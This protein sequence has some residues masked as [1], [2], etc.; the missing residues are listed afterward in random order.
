VHRLAFEH[1]GP[2][3][4]TC[5]SIDASDEMLFDW[6]CT[7]QFN[8]KSLSEQRSACVVRWNPLYWICFIVTFLSLWLGREGHRLVGQAGPV[9]KE[10]RRD[11]Y[12][13]RVHWLYT[14]TGA[15]LWVFV[16]SIL[17]I[18]YDWAEAATVDWA[19]IMVTWA[20]VA[21]YCASN[22]G[23][24]HAIALRRVW[25][26][27]LCVLR[28]AR[29]LAALVQVELGCAA[30]RSVSRTVLLRAMA[31]RNMVGTRCIIVCNAVFA[32]CMLASL[33]TWAADVWWDFADD[34]AGGAIY[35]AYVSPFTLR[36][37]ATPMS[38]LS[39]GVIVVIG[40]SS[41]K[42]PAPWFSS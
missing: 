29:P 28:C 14:T 3:S 37:K 17:T 34:D 19:A 13:V 31:A 36:R 30:P 15:M 7:S 10:E 20:V 1:A 5:W 8:E 12:E 41:S 21:C 4:R 9:S 22:A 25:A 32:L 26:T 42:R 2:W 39:L 23:N 40:M 38:D 11:E 35:K 27:L 16:R 6:L 24:D 18:F 33:C